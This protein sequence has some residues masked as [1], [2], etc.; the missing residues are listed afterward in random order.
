MALTPAVLDPVKPHVLHPRLA[1]LWL[2]RCQTSLK[3]LIYGANFRNY[4]R[5]TDSIQL[6]SPKLP[7]AH[8][9]DK[10]SLLLGINPVAGIFDFLP[11]YGNS[12]LSDQ[13]SGF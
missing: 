3:S 12:G 13:T 10:G 2:I 11:I 5:V 6:D 1:E 4:E 9:Q 8:S 7:L